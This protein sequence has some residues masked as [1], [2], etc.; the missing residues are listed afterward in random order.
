MSSEHTIRKGFPK[1]AVQ[2][3][4]LR[5]SEVRPAQCTS[6]LVSPV[7]GLCILGGLDHDEVDQRVPGENMANINRI[8][9]TVIKERT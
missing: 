3:E 1:S 5:R 4:I 8:N 7:S 6:E 2:T 9:A